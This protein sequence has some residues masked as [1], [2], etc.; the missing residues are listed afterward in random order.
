[1]KMKSPKELEAKCE[2]LYNKACKYAT[3]YY[4]EGY[5]EPLPIK[6]NTKGNRLI[7]RCYSVAY[8]L[9]NVPF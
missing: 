5:G 1:M 9:P 3:D 6:F 2:R 4:C 8:K 7:R